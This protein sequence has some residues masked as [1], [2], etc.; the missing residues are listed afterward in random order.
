MNFRNNEHTALF[1]ER[2]KRVTAKNICNS[3]YVR[4]DVYTSDKRW[5][6]RTPEKDFQ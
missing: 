5:N 6:N 1:Y 3:F 2:A 4:K